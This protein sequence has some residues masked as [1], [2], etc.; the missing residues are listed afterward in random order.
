MKEDRNMIKEFLTE[1]GEPG[2]H[3][4]AGDSSYIFSVFHGFLIHHYCGPKI[5]DDDMEYMMVQVNH[6][7][8]IPSGCKRR[9]VFL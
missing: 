4:T 1:R 8:S 5:S 9:L 3:L 6:D 7:S 2:F